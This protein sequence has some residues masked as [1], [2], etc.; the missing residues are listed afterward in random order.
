VLAILVP[1]AQPG[2]VLVAGAVIA[3]PLPIA[4]RH[5]QAV[6]RAIS[7]CPALM[8]LIGPL[9]AFTGL[10][11]DR[12]S[13]LYPSLPWIAVAAVAGGFGWGLATATML[14]IATTVSAVLGGASLSAAAL[15][16]PSAFGSRLLFAITIA[17]LAEALT[18]IVWTRALASKPR[19]A[20][21]AAGFRGRT[22]DGERHDSPGEPPDAAVIAHGPILIDEPGYVHGQAGDKSRILSVRE[23]EVVALLALGL[24]LSNAADALGIT[25]RAARGRVDRARDRIAA[26][27]T[28]ELVR[29]AIDCGCVPRPSGTRSR[30][31]RG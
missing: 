9:F 21:S 31:D 30:G 6:W 17:A 15:D 28:P 23:R 10:L 12:S 8:L 26:R 19:F 5:Q 4:A 24:S 22:G 25:Y 18:Q 29:W 3:A 1:G 7:R 27:T 13:F 11:A 20:A 2:M 14:N 16:S